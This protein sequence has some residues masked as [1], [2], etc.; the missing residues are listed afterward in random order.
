MHCA[1][2]FNH[3]GSNLEESFLSSSCGDIGPTIMP[4][5]QQSSAIAADVSDPDARR[6]L[7]RGERDSPPSTSGSSSTSRTATPTAVMAR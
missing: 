1:N 3:S 6:R 2:A 7:L 4:L 5:P